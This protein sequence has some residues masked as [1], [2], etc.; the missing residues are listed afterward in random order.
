MTDKLQIARE[1]APALEWLESYAKF[2]GSE[3]LDGQVVI[4]IA[5]LITKQAEQLNRADGLVAAL[6]AQ[7]RVARLLYANAEGCVVNHYGH[8]FEEHGMPGWLSDCARDIQIAR[9]A[10]AEWGME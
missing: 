2:R 7:G 5:A 1:E 9:K 4:K 10:L 3:S 6:R 8:D